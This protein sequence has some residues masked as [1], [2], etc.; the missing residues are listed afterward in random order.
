MVAVTPKPDSA[1]NCSTLSNDKLFFSAS[2]KIADAK[3]CSEPA[4]ILAANCIILPA[5]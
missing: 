4:S 3:G 2:A 1:S 5:V